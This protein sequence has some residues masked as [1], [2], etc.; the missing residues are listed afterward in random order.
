MLNFG[1]LLFHLTHFLAVGRASATCGGCWSGQSSA[2]GSAAI[3][4]SLD[5][6]L[7]AHGSMFLCC[8]KKKPK[9]TPKNQQLCFGL[10]AETSCVCVSMPRWKHVCVTPVRTEGLSLPRVFPVCTGANAA[11][12]GTWTQLAI[13]CILEPVL[14]LEN[15]G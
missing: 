1:A 4:A 6:S 14:N 5:L 12:P 10:E 8:Y 3:G 2:F 11:Q 7:Q 13:P 9:T 15:K